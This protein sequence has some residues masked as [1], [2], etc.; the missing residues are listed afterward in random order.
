MSDTTINLC[1]NIMLKSVKMNF[2]G[3]TEILCVFF[4]RFRIRC[5]LFFSSN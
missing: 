5:F 4:A 1:G 2:S 3:N